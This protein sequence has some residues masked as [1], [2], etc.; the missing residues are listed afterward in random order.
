MWNRER[1][2]CSHWLLTVNFSKLV[3]YFDTHPFL[4][5]FKSE[6]HNSKNEKLSVTELFFWTDISPVWKLRLMIVFSAC[7]KPF[8]RS[9]HDQS[10]IKGYTPETFVFTTFYHTWYFVLQYHSIS[11]LVASVMHLKRTLRSEPVHE[12]VWK[13]IPRVRRTDPRIPRASRSRRGAI[14]MTSER[15]CIVLS[16]TL[17]ILLLS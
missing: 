1:I 14:I 16:L 13:R 8:S 5:L 11:Y 17:T 4:A 6:N 12:R 9:M 7:G 2:C 3:L 10:L 15:F